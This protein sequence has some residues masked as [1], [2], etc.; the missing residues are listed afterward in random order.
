MR[1]TV[2]PDLAVLSLP[3]DVRL[4]L[5]EL[6][7]RRIAGFPDPQLP[8][9]PES[10]GRWVGFALVLRKRQQTGVPGVGSESCRVRNG[11]AGVVADI[12]TW[13]PL[14][15]ILEFR[16]RRKAGSERG[17]R[18]RCWRGRCAT[19]GS[20]CR[21]RRRCW[22]CRRTG[23]GRRCRARA[24]RATSVTANRNPNP[25]H[26][27]RLNVLTMTPKATARLPTLR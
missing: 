19:G 5:H 20:S 26:V 24:G 15:P 7:G 8:H 22:R 16:A 2:Q 18:A 13:N 3:D 21:G 25:A 12:R 27:V 4:E 10:I 11:Q 23:R 17:C 9:S 6:L 14:Q 1:P